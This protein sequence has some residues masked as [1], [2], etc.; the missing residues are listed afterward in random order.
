MCSTFV[1]D[2]LCFSRHLEAAVVWK[3]KD[4]KRNRNWSLCCISTHNGPHV[5]T[6][7]LNRSVLKPLSTPAGTDY[8][9]DLG[10]LSPLFLF[11]SLA[12]RWNPPTAPYHIG[13]LHFGQLGRFVE[14]IVSHSYETFVWKIR[15][16][17][18][19]NTN[20]FLHEAQLISSGTIAHINQLNVF[21]FF[22]YPY[23]IITLIM[24]CSR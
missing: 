13:H 3:Y 9:V 24:I 5:R 15:E 18:D 14:T 8:V 22:S 20:L 10:K 16:S 12:I 17:Y 23:N 11:I 2:M 21:T 4:G 1:M 19:R 7:Y 6:N